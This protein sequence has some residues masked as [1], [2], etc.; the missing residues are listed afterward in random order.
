[1]ERWLSTNQNTVPSAQTGLSAIESARAS[2]RWGSDR[3][4]AILRAARG[5]AGRALPTV[6]VL[7][8]ALFAL[9]LR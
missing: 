2:M 6:L 7:L 1:M 9:L 8:T 4:Q 3:A 5:S